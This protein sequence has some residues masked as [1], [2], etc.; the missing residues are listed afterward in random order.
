MGMLANHLRADSVS[1][2]ITK[3]FDGQHPC[4]MC[5]AIASGKQSEKKS[6]AEVK[7]PRIEFPPTDGPCDRKPDQKLRSVVSPFDEVAESLPKTSPFRP[8]RMIHS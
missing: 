6:E 8:P 7:L 2:A 4:P 5:K 3:T 1:V